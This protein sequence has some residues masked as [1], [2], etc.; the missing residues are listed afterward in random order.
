MLSKT[1]W[2]IFKEKFAIFID[3]DFLVKKGQIRIRT[4]YNYSGPDL[5]N[6]IP[7][8]TGSESS[9]TTLTACLPRLLP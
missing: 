2:T 8:P 9:S 3:K 4:R 6:K 1:N 7:D 5:T